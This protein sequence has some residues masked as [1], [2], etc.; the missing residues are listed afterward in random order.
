MFGHL[1]GASGGAEAVVSALTLRDQV[2]HPTLNQ[3]EKDPE[4]DLD[5]VPNVARKM[6]VD[7]L[8]SN[9]FGFGGHNVTI[10]L[11]GSPASR[12]LAAGRRRRRLRAGSRMTSA[13][14]PTRLE[15][16]GQAHLLR[17]AATLAAAARAAFEAE[18]AAIPWERVAAAFRS[19]DRC[20]S[21]RPAA[22]RVPDLAPPAERGRAS[23]GAS[24]RRG[25]ALLAAG[26]VATVLLA[27]GQGTRLGFPGPK[28]TFVLGPE[29]DRT[30]YAV[31][32]ERVLAVSRA[33]GRPVPL[34]LLVSR[35][36]EH[37][38]R[39]ALEAAGWHGLDPAL[40]RIV[41]Q[42]E[43]PAL[44]AEGRALLAGPGRL[45]LSPDGHGGLVEALRLSGTFDWLAGLGIECVTTHQVDNPLGR[46][47]DP[48]FLG[49][50]LDRR[51]VAAGKAVRKRDPGEKVGMFAR[52][53]DGRVRIVEYSEITPGGG[54]RAPARLHRDPRVLAGLAAPAARGP[55]LH[56]ARSTTPGRRCRRWTEE[57]GLVTPERENAVKLEQFLFD[58]LPLAPRVAVHEVDRAREFAPIKNATGDDS[59]ET[60]RARRRRRDRPLAPRGGPSRARDRVAAS[61]GGRRPRRPR[62]A[63]VRRT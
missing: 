3:D 37:A 1:L 46:A 15:S 40:V 51:A 49:W 23:P 41:R 45:A 12:G 5:Y 44:D 34:V 29:P 52:G 14:R 59:P 9:S 35:E 60:C 33:A 57:A 6:K 13:S 7:T 63:P 48:V 39:A 62:G 53:V 54:G 56:A 19:A 31:L 36:T 38:T 27:G 43:L 55:R 20:A 24:P 8:L 42:G 16:T 11:A 25:R 50:L 26:R 58:L 61:P 21:P 30:L 10:C 32:L 2:V 28:G 22:A 4:C 18:L 17:H 47:L